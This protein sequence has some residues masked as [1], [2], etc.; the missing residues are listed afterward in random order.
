M[1]YALD[2]NPIVARMGEDRNA[3]REIERDMQIANVLAPLTL[4]IA[5]IAVLVAFSVFSGP[6]IDQSTAQHGHNLT[7][8]GHLP[9]RPGE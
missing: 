3:E 5:L 9:A 2:I 1:L 6:V 8:A 7:G 4:I